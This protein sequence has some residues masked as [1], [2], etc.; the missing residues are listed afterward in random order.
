MTGIVS[1]GGY[2][3]WFRLNR[4]TILKAMGW[5]NPAGLPGEKAVANYDE[6]AITMA[7]AA[8]M[9]CL[10]GFDRQNIDALYFATTT[11]PYKERQNANLIAGALDLR[12]DIRTADFT[13]SVKS[14]TSALLAACEAVKA[15]GARQAVVCAGD[16]RLG[17]MGS[18]Q[19]QFFG[20]GAAAFLIGDENVIATIEGSYSLAYDFVDHRRAQKDMFD[21]SWEDRW[22]RDEG[23][24]KFIPQAITGL[25]K[26]YNL[27][28]QDFAKAVYTCPYNREHPAIG[29][30]LGLTP[31]KIQGNLMNEIGDT[32][33]AYA[34]MML[35]S[36]LEEAKPGDKILVV[37]YGNG[38][39]A[40][41]LQ[42]T[43]EI[44]KL[45]G[46]KGIKGHLANKK[47]L[48]SYEKYAVFRNMVPL[49]IG[50]RGEE[51]PFTQISTLYRERKTMLGLVGSKCKKCGTPQFPYQRVCVNPEC[52]AVDQMEDY[53]FSDKKAYLFTYTGDNLAAS[54][55][56]PAVYGIVD[57]EGGGRWKFDLTDCELESVKV[58]MPLQMSFRR[59]FIDEARG[60]FN[61]FWKAVPLREEE[62]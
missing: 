56:P 23:Y 6:D 29:K 19:E 51:I 2:V 1:Y 20:D 10:N 38:C 52:G 47:E 27:N 3:P 44:T 11:A 58:G 14:G 35:V 7:V 12:E 5:F 39:D 16:N 9:D 43:D 15:K 8:S 37:S 60:N 36:A 49:D 13:D 42:V 22:I 17:K 18:Q 53:R 25:L 28:I 46:R 54:P 31:D 55:N 48:T 26:K 50:I 61:Y 32:G 34:L 41:Y 57:F 4:K 33:S 59:K 40:F 21:R 24:L 30:Q 45:K 62:G